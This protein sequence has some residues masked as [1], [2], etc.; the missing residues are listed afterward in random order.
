MPRAFD[1]DDTGAEEAHQYGA[2]DNDADDEYALLYDSDDQGIQVR[3][4]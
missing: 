3:R 2:A 1:N 4:Y